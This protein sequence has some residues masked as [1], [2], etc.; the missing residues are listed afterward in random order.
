MV[1]PNLIRR[2]TMDNRVR[3]TFGSDSE[4]VAYMEAHHREEGFLILAL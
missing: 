3:L 1:K 2:L 4:L